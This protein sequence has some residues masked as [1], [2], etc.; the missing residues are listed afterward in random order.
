[1]IDKI[2]KEYKDKLDDVITAIDTTSNNGS[3]NDVRKHARLNCQAGLYR[4]FITKLEKIKVEYK[5]QVISDFAVW[6]DTEDWQILLEAYNDG[7]E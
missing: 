5:Q 6:M 2:I 7:E 3:I 1:M 4:N